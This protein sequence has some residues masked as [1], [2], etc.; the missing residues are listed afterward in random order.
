[1]SK[2]ASADTMWTDLRERFD[3]RDYIVYLGFL[4]ILLFFSVILHD[5]G[6]LTPRNLMNI[7]RQTTPISVMAIGMA[8]TLSAGEID[9]S[10]GG[11]VALSA[12][13]AGVLLREANLPLAV[14]GALAVG[15]GVG[16]FNGLVTVKIRIPSFLVTLGTLSIVTGLARTITDLEPV[17]VVN[18]TFNFWFGSGSFG[19]VSILL[20]WTAAIL[21]VGH[22]IYRHTPYGR[23]VRAVGGDR[24]AAASVGINTNTIR[25]SVLVLSAVTASLAGLLYAGRLQGARYTL[26][27][28]DL[29]TV[30][31]AVIIGGTRL[32]GGKGSI[33]GA[34]IGSILVGMLNN[35]L[36]LMGLAVAEQMMARG[37]IIILAVA[38]SLRET[39]D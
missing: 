35:G 38:L 30:I 5:D 6:F 13:V 7:V 22:L 18:A 26:G 3:Y 28:A 4:L 20:V 9:L 25:V 14:A 27:E 15:V 31:A 33:V 2:T 1:M 10:I 19:P 16:L 21:G 11:I 29:L 32:F 36:I 12:L 34:V 17:P 23:H 24:R 8:Y 39:K 37:A